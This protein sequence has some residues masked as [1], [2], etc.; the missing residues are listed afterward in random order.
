V[1]K[2]SRPDST[3]LTKDLLALALARPG[4]A[5]EQSEQVLAARPSPYEASI[6]CQA[7]GIVLRDRGDLPGAL[8]RLRRGLAFAQVSQ[9]AERVADVR[10]TLGTALAWSGQTR[11]GLQE[12]NQALEGAR[13]AAAGRILLRRA[14]VRIVV[15]GYEAALAD[16]NAALPRLRKAEDQV[17]LA[18]ALTKRAE[19]NLVLG[20]LSRSTADFNRGETLFWEARQDFEYAMARHNRG[21]AAMARGDL[22]AA[23]RF[24]HE[25]DVRYREVGTT[26]P[27][28]PSDRSAA[29]LAAGLA[30][31]AFD[32]AD[33][34]YEAHRGRAGAA[35]KRAELLYAS[36]LA[37]VT[38]PDLDTAI[39]RASR[40]KR[41]FRAQGRTLWEA[42]SELILIQAELADGQQSAALLRRAVRVVE[43]LS[44][45][46]PDQTHRGHLIAGRIALTLGRRPEAEHHLAQAARSRHRP[47]PLTR[48]QGWL[49]QSLRAEA[50]D[51]SRA[52]LAACRAG[53]EALDAH[54]V[55]L[56]STELRAQATAHGAELTRIALRQTLK[57]GNAWRL[58]AASERWRAAALATQA[59]GRGDTEMTQALTTL[60]MVERQLE[61]NRAEALPIATLTR[62]HRRLER[63]IRN[64]SLQSATLATRRATAVDPAAIRDGLG[65]T[66]LVELV[67]IDGRLHALTVIDGRIRQH[68]LG[69]LP[70]NDLE[71]ARFLLR[72][73]AQRPPRWS[74]EN[75]LNGIGAALEHA[76]LGPAVQE[77]QGEE[78]IV[79]VPPGRLQA[80]PWAMLPALR[81]R[82]VSVA[83]SVLTFLRGRAAVPAEP[84]RVTFVIGPGLD[85]AATEVQRI[86]GG[87]GAPLVLG[88]GNARTEQTL[89][90]LD[91]AWLAHIAAHGRLRV[92]NP[93]FSSLLL[94]DGPL[95][96]HDLERLAQPPSRIVLPCC[97]SGVGVPA[98]ADE[99]L[100]LVSSLLSM[101]T[102]GVVASI[103]PINDAAT[104]ELMV[105]FHESLR[106]GATMPEALLAARE[107]TASDALGVATGLS[108]TAFGT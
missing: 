92:D 36:S 42:R 94:D 11:A 13:G 6:A 62:E 53:L 106:S 76:L 41:L 31:D 9:D 101:G 50:R 49:A 98:G 5:L 39:D 107:K 87:Y 21:L 57:N 89:T 96:V 32:E 12:I 108:F 83:P 45:L 66:R 30:K 29:L 81:H 44:L 15:G 73:T 28:L 33:A 91:G 18:R 74:I 75:Q 69:V 95:T 77:L 54:L 23:L 38:L 97:D 55:T 3:A 90:A 59:Q 64:L 78:P 22:P 56:G 16:L 19:V 37:A 102:S 17:W 14:A 20:A 88:D 7:A 47:A 70:L 93:L 48:S 103:V 26:H 52:T 68:S 35:Y 43:Q 82:P 85:A 79:V 51:D 8:R 71:H 65:I 1:R 104:A 25:A 34:A 27:D 99:L 2:A 100:G 10:A 60:R 86:T 4:E 46:D 105:A 61:T 80:V 24:L 58:L 63:R 40:A 84:G 72:R 67:E